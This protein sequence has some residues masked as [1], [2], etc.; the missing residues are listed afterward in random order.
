MKEALIGV[1]IGWLL[2]ILTMAATTLYKNYRSKQALT[3]EIEDI[4]KI[5]KSMSTTCEYSLGNLVEGGH[6]FTSPTPLKV[7][8]YSSVYPDLFS[9]YDSTERAGVKSVYEL[10]DII[11]DGTKLPDD[12][13]KERFIKLRELH[14]EAVRLEITAQEFLNNGKN[15]RLVNRDDSF[16]DEILMPKIKDTF[17]L[18]QEAGAQIEARLRSENGR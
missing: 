8:V 13:D 14:V 5:A 15:N 2:S 7:H 17:S 12:S 6:M 4:E 10:V 3:A 9:S 11:N 16:Q 18:Y 1:V